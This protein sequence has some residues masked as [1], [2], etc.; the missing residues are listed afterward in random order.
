MSVRRHPGDSGETYDAAKGATSTDPCSEDVF[1]NGWALSRRWRAVSVGVLIGVMSTV[2]APGR[3]GERGGTASVVA[4]VSAD[5]PERTVGYRSQYNLQ[6]R[7]PA[8]YNLEAA[9]LAA[10]AR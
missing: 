2:V 6:P 5:P 8:L 9:Y 10:V 1:V 4:L 7:I 3:S